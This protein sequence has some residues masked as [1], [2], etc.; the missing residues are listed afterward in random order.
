MTASIAA[1]TAV[2]WPGTVA[3]QTLTNLGVING[4]NTVANAMSSDGSLVE[5]NWYANNFGPGGIGGDG[6]FYW[7][8][9][10]GTVACGS[11]TAIVCPPIVTPATTSSAGGVVTVG[12]TI[13]N[14]VTYA[15]RTTAG[16]GT[17]IIQ[18]ILVANDV[19]LGGITLANSIAVSADGTTISGTGPRGNLYD[20]PSWVTDIPV[21]AFARLDL[22]GANDA[23][24]SLVLGGT[25]INNGASAATLTVG[26]DNTSTTFSGTIHDGAQSTAFS[27]VG[28]GTL[29]LNGLQSAFGVAN[30]PL[31]VYGASNY[32]GATTISAG[33]LAAGA[34]NVLS[35]NSAF[36][37]ASG[38]ALDLGGYSQ[39]VATISGPGTVTNSGAAAATLSL[40]VGNATATFSGGI[41]NGASAV[42]LAK[43]GTGL[44][45]L[46]GANS[47]T[48]ATS[49][50]AGTLSV[51][52]SIASSAVTV[53]SGA[54]LT[55]SGA[56]GAANIQDGGTIAA[57][58]G[59]AVL[60]VGGNLTLASG[61]NLIA[62]LATASGDRIAVGGNAAID[63]NLTLS[64]VS[65]T[66]TA[67]TIYTLV[68][69]AGAL[70]GVFSNTSVIGSFGDLIP[71]LSYDAHN[72]FVTLT[73]QT[74][75]KAAPNSPDWN[76]GSNWTS[77]IV[78]SA[79]DTAVFGTTS[80]SAIDI[81]NADDSIAQMNFVAG[82]P[83]Y[84]FNIAGSAL[85]H[86]SLTLSGG[87]I[88]DQSG[89]AP[90]FVASG[91]AGNT[92]VLKFANAVSA[93]D[94]AIYAGAYGSAVFTGL[95]QAG[96]ATLSAGTGGTIDIS[97]FT[98]TSFNAGSIAGGGSFVLGSNALVTGGLGTSTVVSG[99]LSGNGGAL[100]KIGSGR[101]ILSG[102]NTYSGA[103]V[104]S[105]GT[106]QVDGSIASS[107]S[108]TVATGA[109]LQGTGAVGPLTANGILSPGDG[110]GSIATLSVAGNAALA[111]PS[112]YDA[113]ISGNTA[114]KLAVSG[115]LS[116]DGTANLNFVS[117]PHYGDVSVIAS[118]SSISGQ[119]ASIPDTLSGVLY[120]A[121][122]VVNSPG[123]QQLVVDIA[124][125]SLANALSSP[126]PEETTIATVLDQ[127]RASH[128]A[129]LKG[130]YDAIDPLSSGELTAA[131]GSLV[132]GTVRTL[133]ALSQFQ[134]DAISGV[135]WN[136]L[137]NLGAG[138]ETANDAAD[139][140]IAPM[141]AAAAQATSMPML[142]GRGRGYI[143]GSWLNGSV[144]S[145]NSGTH[146][147]V[148]G[149]LLA[150]GVDY[151]AT[152]DLQV[153][154]LIAYSR[155]S[156]SLSG[157]QSKSRSEAYQATAYFRYALDSNWFLDGFAG[158]ARRKVT[159]DRIV[160]AG[161]SLWNLR[162]K[163]NGTVPTTGV[164]LGY[165]AVN[166][167]FE[168]RPSAGLQWSDES[169]SKFTEQGGPAAM[170]YRGL[171]RQSFT[172]RAGFNARATLPVAG[173]AIHPLTSLFLVHEFDR[174]AGNLTTA[175]A[176]TPMNAFSLPFA[177]LTD[178][179]LDLG[180]GLGVTLGE[181]VALDIRYDTTTA[182]SGISFQAWTGKLS[183]RF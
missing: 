117:A 137:G 14:G 5:G 67:G 27:K 86:A 176:V 20:G 75:W 112:V 154:A 168:I 66:Y 30:S 139:N 85:G 130:L 50:N 13:Y 53:A 183:V 159:T 77:G 22:N 145:G 29:I 2:L 61:S 7:T 94:A 135:L 141:H 15:A 178:T 162:G 146:A 104:V 79:G 100:T 175:F 58:P 179:W 98:G 72:A 136:H 36:S 97:G 161:N 152:Q 155:L 156:S 127:A 33:T 55:G 39:S 16:T 122:S 120:P 147:G 177:R 37:I 4:G 45:T 150:G 121:V 172:G 11:G 129:G 144:A 68:N 99:V 21:N 59:V 54:T 65:G 119:F 17:Q 118:A 105:G 71:S 111:S 82:A 158:A 34:T 40:G 41:A 165:D 173:F 126:T 42:A 138:T 110:S 89:N 80:I 153:G 74:A 182:R 88:N 181:S 115:A 123:G 6:S 109:T 24:G 113:D 102:A 128:Y 171:S 78:P 73:A 114:D 92:G 83:A 18:A 103:T 62:E 170:T 149:Y 108:V 8:Q 95:T 125:S 60:N 167:D 12:S 3:A 143:T 31:T 81:R 84:S 1:L 132:P 56:V 70:D 51:T 10:T 23:L 166:G 47:Y 69:A 28:T 49:V 52:G 63:G 169:L 134:T 26:S 32:T 93:G 180:V 140:G 57:G 87:G 48:G 35:P 133:P 90:A 91:V 19:S 46:S 164:S 163:T 101:L 106:L 142:N 107:G 43:N 174:G 9:A 64:A 157:V 151:D 116:V 148:D 160:A 38:A 44:F 131:I 25:V 96:S 76:T 124:A